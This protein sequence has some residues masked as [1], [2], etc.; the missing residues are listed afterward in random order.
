MQWELDEDDDNMVGVKLIAHFKTK[1]D[2][3]YLEA[4]IKCADEQF[5]IFILGDATA[6]ARQEHS[7]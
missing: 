7:W 3:S 5:G 1:I 6:S 4:V 2:D